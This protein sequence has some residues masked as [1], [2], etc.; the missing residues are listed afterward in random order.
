MTPKYESTSLQTGDK[1]KGNALN[2]CVEKH[3]GH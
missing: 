1:L 3:K 2:K